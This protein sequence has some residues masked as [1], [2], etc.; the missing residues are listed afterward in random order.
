[1]HT[2]SIMGPLGPLLV[3]ALGGGGGK[4]CPPA[5]HRPM[6]PLGPFGR[7]RLAGWVC[8]NM[9]APIIAKATDNSGFVSHNTH[10]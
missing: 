7:V 1:M 3:W 6:P 4:L 2:H 10:T 9:A 8:A 5:S